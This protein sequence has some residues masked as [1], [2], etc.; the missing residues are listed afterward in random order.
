M[1]VKTKYLCLLAAVSA[2]DVVIPLP[3]LGIILIYV[4]LERPAWFKDAVFKI[5][6][7]S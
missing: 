6:G 1:T 3:I 7:A 4:V 5:Y 2:V